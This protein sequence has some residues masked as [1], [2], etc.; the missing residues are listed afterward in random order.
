MPRPDDFRLRHAVAD[1]RLTIE[2]QDYGIGAPGWGTIAAE[3][4]L[5]LHIEADAAI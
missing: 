4:T 5:V 3:V 2:R 1:A